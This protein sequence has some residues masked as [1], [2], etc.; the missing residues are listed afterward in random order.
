MMLIGAVGAD[1]DKTRALAVCLILCLH[2][3]AW[4]I[5]MLIWCWRRKTAYF[6]GGSF[7]YS[8]HRRDTSPKAFWSVMA[9]YSVLMLLSLAVVCFCIVTLARGNS[10][11][12]QTVG[13]RATSTSTT[14]SG[15]KGSRSGIGN[16]NRS[17]TNIL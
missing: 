7:G 14:A 15:M 9:Y 17:E 3:L 13:R 5:W 10:A 11:L 16:S 8:A 2:I 6:V 12:P 1:A 4:L